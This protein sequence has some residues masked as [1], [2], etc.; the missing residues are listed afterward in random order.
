[1]ELR[2]RMPQIGRERRPARNDVGRAGEG[3]DPADR[4]ARGLSELGDD[5]VDR[6]RRL[7]GSLHRVAA[8][9][10]RRAAGV[11]AEAG[12]LVL[13]PVHPVDRRNEPDRDPL[14]LEHRALLDVELEKDVDVVAAG[15]VEAVGVE[16][17]VTHRL[18]DRR[19][20]VI[21]DRGRFVRGNPARHRA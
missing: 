21:R 3:G 13:G 11:R 7:R 15:R 10:A 5:S 9:R 20:L 2:L 16:P 12:V 1:M 6:Q 19:S 8:H 18:R 4:P 17:A 14:L